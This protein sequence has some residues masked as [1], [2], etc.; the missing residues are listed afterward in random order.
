M[1]SAIRKPPGR[2]GL[3]ICI[4]TVRYVRFFTGDQGSLEKIISNRRGVGAIICVRTIIIAVAK[5]KINIT[6]NKIISCITQ[7]RIG[8]KTNYSIIYILTTFINNKCLYKHHISKSVRTVIAPECH[9]HLN[10]QRKGVKYRVLSYVAIIHDPPYYL[11]ANKIRMV[12][13]RRH[14]SINTISIFI[15]PG[16]P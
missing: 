11:I 3:A 2:A 9:L 15:Y 4:R 8:P 1:T 13:S 16:G 14:R 12:G 6:T 7:I 5:T 10:A